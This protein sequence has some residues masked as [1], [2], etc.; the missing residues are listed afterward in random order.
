MNELKMQ[1]EL[2]IL[3]IDEVTD[4]L[5]DDEDNKGWITG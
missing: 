1:N 2:F 3:M 4:S 5:G